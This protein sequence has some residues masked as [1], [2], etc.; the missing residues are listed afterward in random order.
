M[1]APPQ[2]FR[3]T[4]EPQFLYALVRSFFFFNRLNLS[5]ANLRSVTKKRASCRTI[6]SPPAQ[7]QQWILHNEDNYRKVQHHHHPVMT[8]EANI[9][10]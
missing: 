4:E 7:S 2:S 6:R 10:C 5:L 1:T 9:L 3:D 8:A